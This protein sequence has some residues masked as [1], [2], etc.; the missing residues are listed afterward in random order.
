[1]QH[2]TTCEEIAPISLDRL[3]MTSTA[4]F[5]VGKEP[6]VN[7]NGFGELYRQPMAWIS[8]LHCQTWLPAEPDPL[9]NIMGK[10]SS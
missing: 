2:S 9:P 4:R 7:L 6:N 3:R 10:D 1:M 8:P 5:N